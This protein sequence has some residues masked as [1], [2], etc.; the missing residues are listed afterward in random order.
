MTD[1]P[2]TPPTEPPTPAQQAAAASKGHPASGRLADPLALAAPGAGAATKFDDMSKIGGSDLVM[3]FTDPSYSKKA[4]RVFIYWVGL[5]PDAP[6]EALTLAG[7]SWPKITKVR[8]PNPD[9]S[10]DDV[11]MPVIGALAR[12]DERT[13]HLI[14]KK[15]PWTVFRFQEE[16]A[17]ANEPGTGQ[18]IADVAKQPSR[19][20]VITAK[21]PEEIAALREQG[22][23]AY[24]YRAQEGDHPAAR[25]LFAQLCPNQKAPARGEYYPDVLEVTGL[26]WPGELITP[27]DK[28]TAKQV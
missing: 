12:F 13:I 19:G 25:Y 8:R 3:D 7:N 15:L 1:A 9:R 18:N 17:E 28:A 20:H 23:P 11:F 21:N 22:R 10:G 27:A 16:K 4:S 5:M 6:V 24:E 26:S 14:A 2:N